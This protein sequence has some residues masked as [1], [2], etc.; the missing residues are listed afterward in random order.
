MLYVEEHPAAK[1]HS[2][3]AFSQ[4]MPA[5]ARRLDT[6]S[7]VLPSLTQGGV[8]QMPDEVRDLDAPPVQLA[9]AAAARRKKRADG[10]ATVEEP[11]PDEEQRSS[12]DG[13]ESDA[14]ETSMRSV[15]SFEG[16]GGGG[17]MAGTRM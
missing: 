6:R 11:L 15:G 7:A 3:A 8:S 9:R 1:R 13:G 12:S 16:Y 4:A 2:S 5:D 14:S 10:T 17:G